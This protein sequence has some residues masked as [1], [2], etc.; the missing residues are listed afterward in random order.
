ML[1]RTII[2]FS[3]LSV[4]TFTAM[5]EADVEYFRS[6]TFKEKK[7]PLSEAV[8]VGNLL[9]VSGNLGIDFSKK[10]L[11]LVPGGIVAET[12]Q[13][14]LN[15]E[16]ALRSSGSSLNQLVK[17][18]VYLANIDEWPKLNKIWPSFFNENFPTRTAIEV[19]RLWRGA[20]VEITCVA[21]VD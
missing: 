17:C 9:F 8:R 3:L 1:L 10:E 11:G 16:N 15:I 6:E 12:K 20:A 14:M 18:T 13:T 5:A 21:Y 4:S 19:K 7:L 2:I